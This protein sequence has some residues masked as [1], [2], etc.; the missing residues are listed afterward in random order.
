MAIV[1]QKEPTAIPFVA[2]KNCA[3][4]GRAIGEGSCNSFPACTA[5]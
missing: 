2:Q 3:V 4:T 5:A 1:R